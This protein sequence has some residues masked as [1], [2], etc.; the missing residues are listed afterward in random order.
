[1]SLL[2]DIQDAAVDG[3]TDL[4]T[5]LRK[6]RLL[7]ARMGS[8]EIE[9]WVQW[10]AS[11]Y[12]DNVS[13]PEYRVWSL[14]LKG[15]FS[16]PAGSGIRNAPI[17]MACVP[18]RVRKSYTHYECRASIASIED[19]LRKSKGGSLQVG[20]GDLALT[21]GMKVYQYQNCVQAWAEFSTVH[22]VEVSNA[23]RNRLLDLAV[24]LWREFPDAGKSGALSTQPS[25]AARV[26][27]IFN[28]VVH[29]GTANL[30][31]T[32]N[33]SNVSFNIVA[34]DMAALSQALS[35]NGIT[36][37]HLGE[38]RDAL[39]AEPAPQD[40]GKFGPRVSAWIAKMLERAA[41]G[42]WSVG[43]G[44]AGSLLATAISR[45]YGIGG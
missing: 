34:G 32:A 12:P 28:T 11:G 44:A 38:L 43:L 19:T 26:T 10:E 16:G 31:G 7:A 27:Q 4:A 5:L 25:E 45:Y 30:V 13:V 14:E 35:S 15:H 1:V 24:A 9:D 39:Q 21:L 42:A 8:R 17:P 20:T 36:E 29:G 33:S 3:K 37:E 23:V 22:F 6:L 18:D 2:E 40:G 41:S